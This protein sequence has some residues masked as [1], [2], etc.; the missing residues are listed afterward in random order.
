MK[1]AHVLSRLTSE[2]WFI[3]PEALHSILGL[4]ES[5]LASGDFAMALKPERGMGDPQGQ[6]EAEPSAPVVPATAVIRINGILGQHLSLMERMCGGEDYGSIV[7]RVAAAI[8]DPAVSAIVLHINSRGGMAIGC[9]ECYGQLSRLRASA[10]KPMIAFVDGV[11]ASAAMYLASSCQAIVC[12]ESAQ[13]GSIGTILTVEDRTE[14]NAKEGVKR[15][16]FKTAT[17]KDIGSPDRPMTDEERTVLQSRVDFLGGMFIR[18]FTAGRAAAG[19]V[20]TPE[21]FATGLTWFGQQALDR[22]LADEIAPSLNDFLARLV[23][24]ATV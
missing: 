8:A 9:G 13:L 1:F 17:M 4:L 14:K 7:E 11:C 15:F 24:P 5:R 21:V 10:G 16:S 22:G 19:A 18:D 3:T 2:P 6:E 12:T 20:V 23:A